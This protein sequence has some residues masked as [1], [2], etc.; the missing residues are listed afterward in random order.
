MIP[1][2]KQYSR[3]ATFFSREQLCHFVPVFKEDLYLVSFP[4]Q[5]SVHSATRLINNDNNLQLRTSKC[6]P[7]LGTLM[8][9]DLRRRN[10]PRKKKLLLERV[11]EL[12]SGQPL[13]PVGRGICTAGR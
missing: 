1:L 6:A 4:L 13:L 2:V 8:L 12:E 7:F 9:L 3:A 5:V 10:L 11:F